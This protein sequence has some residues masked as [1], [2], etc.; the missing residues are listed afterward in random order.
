MSV[1]YK[2]VPKGQP[3]VVG[4][5]TTKYY[6]SLVRGEKVD[7]RKFAEDIA[8][9]N[10]LSTTAVYAVLEAFF[11]RSNHYLSNGQILDLSQFGTFLP[12]L[13]SKGVDTP[14]EVNPNSFKKFYVNYRPAKIQKRLMRNVEFQKVNNGATE[15]PVP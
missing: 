8:E 11:K 5:G 1:K 4:G 2:V 10:L 14:E 15:E 3:G 6:A 9:M 7:T 13:G 12:Y